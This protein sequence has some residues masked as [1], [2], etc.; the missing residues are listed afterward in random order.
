MPRDHIL[1]DNFRSLSILAKLYCQ[2]VRIVFCDNI[3]Q[4][5]NQFWFP[6]RDVCGAL[7]KVSDAEHLIFIAL[8]TLNR[9]NVIIQ[10]KGDV[11][12]VVGDWF[13]AEQ[14]QHSF[15]VGKSICLLPAVQMKS[16]VTPVFATLIFD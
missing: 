11:S 3:I 14:V 4:S 15:Q 8:F 2:H 9:L 6:E 16:M 10:T 12:P 5:V 1:S 13:A 7:L